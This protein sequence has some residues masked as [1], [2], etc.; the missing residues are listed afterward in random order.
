MTDTSASHSVSQDADLEAPS[1]KEASPKEA[2][3][4]AANSKEARPEDAPL[5][6]PSRPRR[7]WLW[8][9][10]SVLFLIAVI[11]MLLE[12]EDTANVTRNPAP[13]PAQTVTVVTVAPEETI[14]TV[15]AFAG[16][17]PRW[18]AEI[19]AAVSGRI[20]AVQE[21]ALAGQRVKA[22]TPLF[23]IEKT[24]YE[25]AVAAAELGL[26]QAKLAHWRAKNAVALARAEFERAGTTPPN[27][28]AL[29]LPDLRI[30][31][32]T[33]TSAE[34]EL[35]AARRQLAYTEVTAPFSGF[36]IERMASL[37]QTVTAGE[38]LIHLS[39]DDRYE[40]VAELSHA[41]WAL[42]DHPI[43]GKDARLFHRDGTPLGSARIRQGGGF[44]DQQTRQPRVF[45]EVTDP[46]DGVLAG[47]FVRVAF[48]GRP[49]ADTLALPETALTRSGHVWFVDDEDRL[50]RIEPQILFRTGDT[51]VIK[52][53]VSED[54]GEDGPWRVATT[55]L[56][57]FL[58]G[59][60]VAPQEAS[61]LTQTED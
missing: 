20:T 12:T 10:L 33:V 15:T 14:A 1:P 23:S 11:T 47:D 32:R 51:L 44:L 13:P 5:E 37:G 8:I 26:E 31:E 30:A 56:A 50:Q 46:G 41:D 57:S 28:L 49:I 34:A 40:L 9:T 39:D 24:Q 22:G 16:L 38:P 29:R 48:T 2:N 35:E 58:P 36:V 42:L 3:S 54:L 61:A 19:R 55:P 59:Q 4:K 60:R 17:R 45:M 7:R 52:A 6:E 43:S 53:P 21:S 18:D 27:D 25:T